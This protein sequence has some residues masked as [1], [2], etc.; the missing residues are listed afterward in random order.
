MNNAYGDKAWEYVM[1]LV[2]D[3]NGRHTDNGDNPFL[4]K[5]ARL[6]KTANVGNNLRVTFLQF[7]S[8]PR[9][10][11]VLSNK[12]LALGLTKRPQIEKAK[13][14]CGIALWKSFGFYDTNISRTIE[15]Q[16]KGTTNIRQKL[17]EISMK[18]PEFADAITWGAL[19]NACEYEVARTTK[20]KIGSE[21]FNQEVGLKLR[22]VVYATQVVDSILTRSQIMRSKSGLTQVATSYMSEPTLTANILMDAAFEFQ[23]EK[24]I[25][26]SSKAAWQKTGKLVTLAVG[27]Y[28]SLQ[29]ISSIAESLADAWRDDDEEEFKEKFM[30]AFGENLIT[31]L[32]P[33]NKVP[34]LADI[35]ELLLSFFGIGFV[36]SDNLATQWITQASTAVKTWSE[37]LGEARGDKNT[38]KTVYNAI[39]QSVKALSSMT[40]V[41]VSGAMREVVA[42]WNNTA[43]AADIRLKINLYD[44]SNAA[45]G[46]ELYE[47]IVDGDT[48]RAGQ[49]R[50]M[51]GDQKEIEALLRSEVKERYKDGSA[52][53]N[54][55]VRVLATHGGLTQDEAESRVRYW[56]FT[57]DYPEY[58]DLSEA[59]VNKYYDGLYKDGK[60]YGKSAKDLGISLEIYALYDRETKGLTK[61]DD[62]MYIIQTL[63]L[64]A[65][66]KDGLYYL[67]GWAK[68]EID[69][70]PWR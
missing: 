58:D 52:T 66:Q 38:S 30:E 51:L 46:K 33:F 28:L 53:K 42:V 55:A 3:I 8:Y 41:A 34:I 9:A 20:N 12:S 22:E 50:D 48:E 27:S 63:P 69:N 2:K 65:A 39:Y 64:T 19:W 45:L 11:M 57:K 26:G 6:Q 17:I 68:S 43:G 29:L 32:V 23:K 59:D 62:I 44:F 25:T 54:E 21:A 16:I 60:I 40:G 67:N 5:M 10:V 13:T 47:A 1:N 35:S 31:N 70:A 37:V 4:M 49:V 24:R 36:S 14:Y 61:K 7:T 56:K 15:E 18:G